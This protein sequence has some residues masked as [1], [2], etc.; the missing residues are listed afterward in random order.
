MS[1]RRT[2]KQKTPP[3]TQLAR[4]KRDPS[5]LI[6]RGPWLRDV[7]FG[8]GT[9]MDI[10][11]DGHRIILTTPGPGAVAPGTPSSLEREVRLARV[12]LRKGRKP[13]CKP[14]R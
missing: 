5:C 11:R 3:A 4:I 6:L 7:G 13:P 2:N 10:A 14:R 12:H 1:K 9:P 8:E